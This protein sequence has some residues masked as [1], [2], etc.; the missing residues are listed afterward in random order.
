MEETP[1]SVSTPSRERAN[2]RPITLSDLLTIRD[3]EGVSIS[4]NGKYVAFVTSQAV[5]KTNDYRSRLF[6]VR[7]KPG[8][9]PVELGSAG[10]PHWDSTNQ[11]AEEAPQWSPDSGFITY[12]MRRYVNEQWQVWRWNR[13]GG[14]PVQLTHVPGDVIGYHWTLDGSRLI[15]TV[16]NSRDP[17]E[18]VQ[19]SEHGIVYDGK[20]DPW[21]SFPIVNE[22]LARRSTPTETW[23]YEFSN[24]R[25]KLANQLEKSSFG[26]W[27]SDLDEQ[28]FDEK[29]ETF[30]GHHITDAEKSPDGKWVAYRYLVDDPSQAQSFEISLF[31]KPARGGRPVKLAP[32]PG[33]FYVGQYWWSRDSSNI[34]FSEFAPD[35][36]AG[37]LMVIGKGGGAP[38]LLFRANAQEFFGTFS[39][40][41]DGRYAACVNDNNETPP[42]LVVIDLMT[43]QV[44]PIAELNK[45][46]RNIEMSQATRIDGTNQYGDSWFAHVLKPIGYQAGK[47]YPLIVTTYRSGDYFLRGASG[48]ENPIQV[49]AASGFVVLSFDVGFSRNIRPGDFKTELLTW[50]SPTASIEMA[51]RLLVDQGLVD[52]QRVGISGYSHGAEIVA[53]ALTHTNLFHAASGAGGY[54]PYFYYLGGEVWQNKFAEWGLG[55]WPEGVVRE[56]WKELAGSLRADKIHTALLNQVSD[57]E[58]L[59]YLSLHTSLQKLGRPVEMVI[60]PD[61]LHVINQ[62]KHRYEIYERNLDWFRFWLKGEDDADPNKQAQYAR[63]RR[64]RD[65]DQ[66]VP[67]AIP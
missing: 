30:Q 32:S 37:K 13:N 9:V 23:I 24:S 40:D 14:T 38:R 66:L 58:Y 2:L 33:G 17:K 46:F 53:Y 51:V 54:D 6:V 10:L 28:V 62:P 7:T 15:M 16:Q 63:W 29:Q 19:L 8:S 25:E 11:W 47:R 36:R 39:V 5:Y 50:A 48:N 27:I 22:V 59:G 31:S 18:I 4:P 56:K 21:K 67:D 55:G 45:G 44:R 26:A 20:V 52:V 65:Q 43:G 12:R 64:L 1:S 42:G 57:S 34:Y 60:Y 61:E 41:N 3:C 49:Y 35:G